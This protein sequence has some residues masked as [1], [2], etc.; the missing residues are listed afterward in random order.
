MMGLDFVA[1]AANPFA[2]AADAASWAMGTDA[3]TQ[4]ANSFG[5]ANNPTS[6]TEPT[7]ASTAGVM[8]HDFMADLF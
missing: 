3:G 4:I 2:M 6:G 1:E 7:L 5:V 8:A